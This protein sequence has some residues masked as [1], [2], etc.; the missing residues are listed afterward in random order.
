MRQHRQSVCWGWVAVLYYHHSWK[1]VFLFIYYFWDLFKLHDDDARCSFSFAEH[2]S[3]AGDVLVLNF[4]GRIDRHLSHC[5]MQELLVTSR[6]RCC[7]F[8]H[9]SCL[10]RSSSGSQDQRLDDALIGGT[11]ICKRW[12]GGL[13]QRPGSRQHTQCL[14]V[15]LR[16][17]PPAACNKHWLHNS[18]LAWRRLIPLE[19]SRE[20]KKITLLL[21]LAGSKIKVPKGAQPRGFAF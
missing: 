1:V 8:C 16:P 5:I 11:V 9:F 3:L 6:T 20:K 21:F 18:R 7:C 4:N 15:V 10:L 12:R 14:H 19:E 2:N 17:S 13:K